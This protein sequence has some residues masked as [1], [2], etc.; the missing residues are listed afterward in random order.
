MLTVSRSLA[1]AHASP[2]LSAAAHDRVP[3]C[4]LQAPRAWRVKAARVVEQQG[5]GALVLALT[6]VLDC[7]AR[8]GGTLIVS[9][10]F[11]NPAPLP[12]S[13]THDDSIRVS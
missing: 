5:G 7:G 2:Q 12:I 10:L 6:A 11:R 13:T 8:T 1:P 4:G 3:R 9:L